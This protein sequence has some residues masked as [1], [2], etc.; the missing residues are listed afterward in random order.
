MNAAVGWLGALVVG[1]IL[2]VLIIEAALA[3]VEAY[4]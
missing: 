3:L 1:A 2:W 4:G